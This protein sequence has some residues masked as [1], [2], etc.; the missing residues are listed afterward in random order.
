[1]S[2]EVASGMH[3][4]FVRGIAQLCYQLRADGEHAPVGGG[5]GVRVLCRGA[6]SQRPASI[7]SVQQVLLRRALGC[8]RLMT[9]VS[10]G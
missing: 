10:L 2:G 8:V 1:M 6:S 3:A 4:R 9:E 7:T 5:L